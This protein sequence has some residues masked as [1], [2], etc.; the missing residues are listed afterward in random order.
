MTDEPWEGYVSTRTSPDRSRVKEERM[1]LELGL[2]DLIGGLCAACGIVLAFS[3]WLIYPI[4]PFLLMGAIY[5]T[6]RYG[7]PAAFRVTVRAA[8][9][10]RVWARELAHGIGIAIM[11]ATRVPAPVPVQHRR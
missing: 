3:L 4:V 10:T 7:V 11:D 5:A 8:V 2:L 1:L 6:A 9:A